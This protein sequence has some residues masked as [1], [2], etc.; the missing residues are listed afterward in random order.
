M[1]PRLA[2]GEW[3]STDAIRGYRYPKRTRPAR[4]LTLVSRRVLP[5]FSL[6]LCYFWL[7]ATF[8]QHLC[9][10]LLPGFYLPLSSLVSERSQPL[11]ALSL[12]QD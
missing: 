6:T 8:N 2:G 12:R 1:V 9:L 4:M 11:F 7:Q 10:L 5:C 3:A